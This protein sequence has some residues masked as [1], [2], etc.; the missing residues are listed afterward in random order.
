MTP[1]KDIKDEETRED[2]YEA[3]GRIPDASERTGEHGGGSD[4]N[5]T[6]TRISTTA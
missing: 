6:N 3:E 1:S 2:G 4:S 5:E